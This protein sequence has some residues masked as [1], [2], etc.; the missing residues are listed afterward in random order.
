MDVAEVMSQEWV[1]NLNL[2]ENDKL[3]CL[4]MI[5]TLIKDGA[6]LDDINYFILFILNII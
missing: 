6:D 4:E 1:V 3:E 2:D 5:E